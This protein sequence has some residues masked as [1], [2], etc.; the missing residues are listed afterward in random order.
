MSVI[1]CMSAVTTPGKRG[2]DYR[3]EL[4]FRYVTGV[5]RALRRILFGARLEI[6]LIVTM[7]SSLVKSRNGSL[8]GGAG[9]GS[10]A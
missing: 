7:G 6:I 4:V 8:P 2:A 10:D 1:D 9:G 3:R 5:S